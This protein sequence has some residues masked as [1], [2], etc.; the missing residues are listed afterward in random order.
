MDTNIICEIEQKLNYVFR[1]KHLIEQAF[2]H[3]SFANMENIPDNERMEHFGDA[4]LQFISSEYLFHRF[5]Q[6]K[7]G[8]LSQ[9]RVKVVSSKYIGSIVE[10]L[11]LIRYLQVAKGT[12][13]EGLE[14][15]LLEAIICAIYLDGGMDKAREF[16]LTVLKDKLNC[17][18]SG[19]IKDDKTK[20]QEYCQGKGMPLPKY[21]LV[22]ESGPKDCPKFKCA[23]YIN[24]KLESYGEGKQKKLAQQD[25]AHKIVEKWRID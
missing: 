9:L 17:I 14:T 6:S 8:K 20:L 24:G 1:D 15:D 5:P 11:D 12:K 21:E 25:A 18:T 3:S 2:T 23:L 7:E 10:N 13:T 4:I 19:D 22:E 16:V